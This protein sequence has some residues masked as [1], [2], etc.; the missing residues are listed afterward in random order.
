MFVESSVPP[1]AIEAVRESVTAGGGRVAIAPRHLFS[2]AMG[3]PGD[4]G[5][6]YIGML[7]ENVSVIVMSFGYDLPAWPDGLLPEM[8]QELLTLE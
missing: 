1:D 4:F 3:A 8:P 7:A 5:G 6:T 2:D